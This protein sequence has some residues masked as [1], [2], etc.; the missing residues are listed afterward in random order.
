MKNIDDVVNENVGIKP[1]FAHK[2]D[3]GQFTK[4]VWSPDGQLLALI[5]SENRVLILQSDTG[6]LYRE[7]K[8][9]G[10]HNIAWSPNSQLLA[11][12]TDGSKIQLWDIAAGN[13]K[14]KYEGHTDII[15]GMT[16]SPNG[17][18]F[19]SGSK[20]RKILLWNPE[21]HQGLRVLVDLT[22]PVQG[23]SWSPNGHKIASWSNDTTIRIWNTDTGEVKL[24]Y[25][26]HSGSIRGLAWSPDDQFIAFWSADNNITVVRA[27]TL[28]LLCILTGHSSSIYDVV[29]SPDSQAIVSA[30]DDRTIRVWDVNIG[31]LTDIL[32]GH[33]ST[34]ISL[35]FSA[36]GRILASKS[37]DGTIKLWQCHVWS[38]IMSFETETP[39]REIAFNPEKLLLASINRNKPVVS[40]WELDVNV[41]FKN[42]PPD[43]TRYYTN[44]KVVLVGDSGVGK[45]GLGLVLTGQPFTPTS[46][47]HGRRVWGLNSQEIVLNNGRSELRETLLWDLAGQPGYRLIHQLHLNEVAVA[48]VVFDAHS[49][50]DPFS[51]VR[52]WDRAL[53]QAER[54]NNSS[55]TQVKKFLVAA[56]TDRGGIKASRQRVDLLI[57]NLNFDDYL[58][59]SSKEGWQINVLL[60]KINKCID[61]RLLPK[62]SSTELFQKIKTFLTTEKSSG[63]IL[64][65][66]SDLYRSFLLLSVDFLESV[67]LWTQ[68]E[69]CIGRVEARGLIRRLS[70][71]NLIL[72]QPE[73]LDTYASALVNAAKEEPDGLGY[74]FEE[75]AR[76]GR[77]RISSDERLKDKEQEKLL[78]IATIEDLLRHEIALREQADEGPYLVFPSQLT[79]EKPNLSDAPGITVVF[80]F[81]GALMNVYSTLVVRLTHSGLFRKKEYWKNAA[82]FTSQISGTCGVILNELEE[83]RG[84]LSVFFDSDASD[85]TKY[86][87]TEYIHA[88]LRRRAVAQSIYRKPVFICPSCD[89]PVTELQA[90]RRRDRG[91]DSI[92]CSVCETT[93]SILDQ[94]DKLNLFRKSSVSYIDS[95]A[96]KQREKDAFTATLQGKKATDSFDVYIELNE[97]DKNWFDDWLSPMMEQKGIYAYPSYNSENKQYSLDVKNSIEKGIKI[98]VL[99]TSKWAYYSSIDFSTDYAKSEKP[100]NVY[101][102]IM[103]LKFEPVNLPRFFSRFEYIDLINV[104]HRQKSF[105]NILSFIQTN[106]PVFSSPSQ[107]ISAEE[108]LHLEALLEEKR[109]RLQKLEIQEAKLGDASPPHLTNEIEDLLSEIAELEKRIS[110]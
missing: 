20:D 7:L 88:H 98:I 92:E 63:R 27:E 17:Q 21:R 90:Q 97:Q 16:W 80:V 62:V 25:T 38:L 106:R 28:D 15:S 48:L 32:E 77:F 72:L 85:E 51:G 93:V 103:I 84:E 10:V 1:C 86:Q 55:A 78:L 107:N 75:D 53:K 50:V 22:G 95:A 108:R 19:A 99:V 104:N 31:R 58:E 59:T 47:T 14:W 89:T 69:T 101:Q 79:R 64:S 30:S 23:L 71:G 81:E 36:D 34:V 13:Q 76:N 2:I 40:V 4:I 68:F 94:E 3:T 9:A 6:H 109:K 46:S 54:I 29:W 26:T 42:A 96:D 91:F 5:T 105:E 49:E 110:L 83:G 102:Q 8:V 100:I 73:L 52:H 82:S 70:F 39:G 24:V 41:L 11:T 33:V 37:V 44:A 66:N 18:I 12:D 45:S 43:G 35:S 57:K 61:W 74:I 87:F 67:D 56:R 65:T 60:E